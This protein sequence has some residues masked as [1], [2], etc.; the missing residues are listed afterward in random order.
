[1]NVTGIILGEPPAPGAVTVTFAVCV[2]AV[3]PAID[4]DTVIVPAFVPLAGVT[5]SHGA[6]SDAVHSACRRPCWS[7]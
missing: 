2:P 6:S 3:S 7:R 4:A 1:M 5:V